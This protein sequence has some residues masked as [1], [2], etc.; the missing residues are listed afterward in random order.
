MKGPKT[1]TPP[2]PVFWT[3][4]GQKLINNGQT[5]F[6]AAISNCSSSILKDAELHPNVL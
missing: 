2:G 1:N 4:S 5:P 3:R 6:S